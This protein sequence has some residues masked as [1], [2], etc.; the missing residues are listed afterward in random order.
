MMGQGVLIREVLEGSL[1]SLIGMA[2]GD[3]LI[4][5][6]GNELRDLI[7]IEFY[8]AEP[9]VVML[10]EDGKGKR[11]EVSL[12]KDPDESLGLVADPPAIKRCPNKC[13]FCFVD[14]MPEGQRKTLYIRDED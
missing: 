8:Q 7:D 13:D 11:F 14:Q 2:S 6:N 10:W 9:E 12:E 3:R 5:I 1:G 4:S